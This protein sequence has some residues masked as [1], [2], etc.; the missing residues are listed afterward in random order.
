MEK[1]SDDDLGAELDKKFHY[2]I[3]QSCGNMLISTI[4][5]SISS[6]VEKYI[7]SSHMHKYSKEKINCQHKAIYTAL[8]EHDEKEA[9][10]LLREHL[11]CGIN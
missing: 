9:F 10:K 2:K 6:L 4:M 8:K 11:E 3:A 1:T 5:F 7:D